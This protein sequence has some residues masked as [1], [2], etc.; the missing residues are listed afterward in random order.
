MTVQ[1]KYCPLLQEEDLC[2]VYV[3]NL[4]SKADEVAVR[5]VFETCGDVLSINLAGCTP[6]IKRTVLLVQVLERTVQIVVA[7]CTCFAPFETQT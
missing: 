5:S 7:H 3:G 6:S 1:Y 2:T 4:T